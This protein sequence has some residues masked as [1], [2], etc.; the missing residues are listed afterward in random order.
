MI[1]LAKKNDKVIVHADKQA[2]LDLDGLIPEMEVSEAE[3]ESAEG[4]VRVI[5]GNIILGLTAQE[6]A[7]TVLKTHVDSYKAELAIIDKEAGAGRKIRWITLAAAAKSGVIRE[8]GND[9]D[10][11]AKLE[12]RANE[13]RDKISELE[14]HNF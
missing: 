8:N 1:Y 10:K 7:E 14:R 6:K 13:L 2:M 9:Y 12:E 5:E 3:F 11:L 4:L